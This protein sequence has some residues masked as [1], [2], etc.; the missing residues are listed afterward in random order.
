MTA[1][2]PTHAGIDNTGDTTEGPM[3]KFD[4][5]ATLSGAYDAVTPAQIGGVSR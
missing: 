5:R 2:E 3:I 1:T 4:A